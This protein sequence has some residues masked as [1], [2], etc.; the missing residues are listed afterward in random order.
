MEVLSIAQQIDAVF[1][2]GCSTLLMFIILGIGLFYSG[3]TQRKSALSQISLPLI[4]SCIIF[5]EW[6]FIG[7]T[8]CYSTTAS[9]RYIGNFHNVGLRYLTS[10]VVEIEGEARVPAYIHVLFEGL[11]C[12]ITGSLAFGC[13]AERGRFKPLFLFI[14]IWCIIIYYPVSYWH[15]NEKGWLKLDLNIMDFAG[16]DPVHLLSGSTSLCYSLKLGK[17]SY[18]SVTKNYRNS[19]TGLILI[20][21]F[22]MIIGWLGFNGGCSY[23]MSFQTLIILINTLTS[24]FIAGFTWFALDYYYNRNFSIIGL[25]SGC[26]AGLVVI[27]PSAGFVNFW[28]SFVIGFIGGAVCNF[29][30]GLKFLLKI[31]DCLDIFAIH[32]CGGFVG[33]LLTGLFADKN[34][35]QLGVVDIKGGWISHRYIALLYQFIGSIVTLCYCF[36]MSFIFLTI[37]DKIPGLSLKLQDEDTLLKGCDEYEFGNE[38]INDY[39]EFVRILEPGDFLSDSAADDHEV[40]NIELNKLYNSNS[41]T[42][43]ENNI[44]DNG[45]NAPNGTNSANT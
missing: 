28:S 39:V 21:T 18:N 3:L 36:S 17:R 2:F 25:C 29:A 7:Y 23:H 24:C 5:V 35:A 45:V 11:F 43:N 16:G 33:S 6:V 4:I 26:V 1:L 37:I 10:S 13:I 40:E 31:D 42:G 19:N 38:Y 32:G 41:T 14:I 12:C 20:G 15:W 22:L 27:T 9:N 34:I 8:L 30:T 44:V